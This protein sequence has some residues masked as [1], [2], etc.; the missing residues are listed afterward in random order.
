L[1]LKIKGLTILFVIG[2]L[3]FSQPSQAF[4]PE[5]NTIRIMTFSDA[6]AEGSV[7]IGTFVNITIVIKNLTNETM[8]N[9]TIFQK[10]IN[11][12]AEEAIKLMKTPY[13]DYF[14]EPINYTESEIP[15][16]TVTNSLTNQAIFANYLNVTESNITL[17]IPE[18]LAGD[19]IGLTY[20]FNFTDEG[21]YIFNAADI[22]YYDHWGD[23][24]N[25]KSFNE[26]SVNVAAAD[27]NSIAPYI[28]SFETTEINFMLIFGLTFGVV[29][30]ALVSRGLYLKK[31][32]EI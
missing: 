11:D 22:T 14:G 19:E 5:E 27:E 32:F 28:P 20:T 13:G 23:E 7:E 6:A 21:I 8:N 16:L 17:N 26:V 9:V 24:K 18:I 29:I 2:V 25:L 15:G 10:Y 30:I 1:N 31:P 3:L 4:I 12:P